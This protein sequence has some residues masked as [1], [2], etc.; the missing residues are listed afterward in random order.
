L[1]ITLAGLALLVAAGA[2]R[3]PVDET[4]ATEPLALA[5]AP[6]GPVKAMTSALLWHQLLQRQVAGGDSDAVAALCSALL[7]LHPDLVSVREYLANQLVIHEASRAPDRARHLMLVMQGLALLEDGIGR[8][9]DPRLSGSLGRLLYWRPRIDPWF[10]PAVEQ[11]Y[12]L[13][14]EELAIETLRRSTDEDDTL[15]LADLLVER[16]LTTLRSEGDRWRARRDLVEA[17]GLLESIQ[18]QP[19]VVDRA[20]APL[21]DSL[22]DTE[23]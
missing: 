15:L 6:L 9:G 19:G 2:L 5:L 21:L 8:G 1:R 22:E 17:R 3:P 16:G 11:Y 7:E 13:S 18:L 20:L 12:G 10:A 23:P 4:Q 14:P